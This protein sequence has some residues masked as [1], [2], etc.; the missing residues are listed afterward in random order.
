MSVPNHIAIIM[1]GNGRW[2]EKRGLPK[3]E[4][5]RRGVETVKKIVRSCIDLDVKYL[6]LYAFST[7]NWLRPKKEVS[8]LFNLLHNFL[9]SQM[10]L[11]HENKVRLRIIGERDKLDKKL[12]K[13]IEKHEADT[14]SYDVLEVNIALSY[15]SRQEIITACR[16]IVEDVKKGKLEPSRINEEIFSKYLYTKDSPDPDLLIRTSGEM[17]LSNFLLWQLSYAEIYVT[18]KFWPDFKKEDL[19]EAIGEYEKRERRFGK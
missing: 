10:S 7:E 6:T 13:K 14:S 17:R 16:A 15:G 11:F 5:H 8:A 9:D 12:I 18:K 19:K 2:A 4:G 3:I 1:D